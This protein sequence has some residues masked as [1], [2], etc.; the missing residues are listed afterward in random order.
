MNSSFR[1]LGIDPGFERRSLGA[2]LAESPIGPEPHPFDH[3]AGFLP[4]SRYRLPSLKGSKK[5]IIWSHIFLSKTLAF[6]IRVRIWPFACSPTALAHVFCLTGIFW[7][8][9]LEQKSRSSNIF[10]LPS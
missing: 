8:N 3:S 9:R 2:V 5:G 10:Q 6:V 7:K 4:L 1:S